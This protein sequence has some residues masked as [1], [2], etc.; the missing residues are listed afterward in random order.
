M[1]AVTGALDVRPQ[2]PTEFDPGERH[3][4]CGDGAV[5]GATWLLDEGRIDGLTW[6]ILTGLGAYLACVPFGSALFDRVIAHTRFAGTAAFCITPGD[7]VGDTGSAS[8]QLLKDLGSGGVSKL[9][10]FKTF[11]YGMA[12]GGAALLTLAGVYLVRQS[13]AK[14]V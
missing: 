1:L 6:L 11:S 13:P 4:G 7:A 14:E 8:V 9:A 3:G 10:F 12:V 5:G 2:P